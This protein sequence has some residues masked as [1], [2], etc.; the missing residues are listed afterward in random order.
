MG[1]ALPISVVMTDME[2]GECGIQFSVP[3]MWRAEKKR[4]GG[5]WYC[6][7]GHSRVYSESDA[8]KYKR[9]LAEETGRHDRTLAQKNEAQHEAAAAKADLA[10]AKKR[11]KHGV[12]P[13][14]NR[15]F[16]QLAAHMKSKHPEYAK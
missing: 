16:K 14:C 4:N 13:C 15:T 11:A 3:E 10:R 12:C 5:S 2:C 7:N 6:P 9:L 1:Y 8:D